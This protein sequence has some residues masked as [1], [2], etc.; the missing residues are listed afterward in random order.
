MQHK[1][2]D[3]INFNSHKLPNMESTY[4]SAQTF[5]VASHR[6]QRESDDG[7]GENYIIVTKNRDTLSLKIISDS[8]VVH[9][10]FLLY[11][12]QRRIYVERFRYNY[13]EEGKSKISRTRRMQFEAKK[14]KDR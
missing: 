12:F 8:H 4:V 6:M 11:T 7:V 2:L 13:Q 9:A 10:H 14:Q 3:Q 1:K 5:S